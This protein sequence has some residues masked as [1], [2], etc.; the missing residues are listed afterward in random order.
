MFV[1]LPYINVIDFVSCAKCHLFGL[2]GTLL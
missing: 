2:L 1:F